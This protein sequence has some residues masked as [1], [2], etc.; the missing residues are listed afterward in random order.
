FL[1]HA[2]G[3][4]RSLFTGSSGFTASV[5]EKG[6]GVGASLFLKTRLVLTRALHF[7]EGV[8]NFRR[9]AGVLD[10]DLADSHAKAVVR[11]RVLG[12]AQNVGLNTG[13]VVRIDFLG[14]TATDDF[15]HGAFS[16]V[17]HQGILIAH[18]E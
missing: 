1:N 11:K 3:I 8:D 17:T 5:T 2:V 7:V 16:S 10:Q 14:R 9:R 12:D 6:V 15:A 13:T 18:V 4:G